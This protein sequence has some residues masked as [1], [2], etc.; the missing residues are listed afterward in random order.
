VKPDSA[1]GAAVR[2]C[3]S[4]VDVDTKKWYSFDMAKNT[5]FSLGDYFADFIDT[6]VA[7]GRYGS[8]SDVVR[9]SLR[10]LEDRESKLERL[11]DALIAGEES[12]P[13]RPFDFDA[14]LKRKNREYRTRKHKPSK[15]R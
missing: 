13:S 8:A 12:G 9:A 1:A 7:S 2:W 4:S 14:F 6:Q 3:T 5:S 10:L 15:T 11:R